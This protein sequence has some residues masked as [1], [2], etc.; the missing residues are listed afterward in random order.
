MAVCCAGQQLAKNEQ[1]VPQG[2]ICPRGPD[3]GCQLVSLF[4]NIDY[5]QL[6]F[7]RIF[8]LNVSL[9]SPPICSY[10]CIF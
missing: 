2:A 4:L 9:L 10:Y 5:F 7:K 3:G 8:I 1:R 6:L